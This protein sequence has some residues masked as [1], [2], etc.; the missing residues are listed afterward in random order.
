[1]MVMEPSSTFATLLRV[2]HD[3]NRTLPQQITHRIRIMDH[4]IEND[5][6]AGLRLVDASGLKIRWQMDHMK[7]TNTND[8]AN[9]PQCNLGRTA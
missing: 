4:D 8:V 3:V 9:L 5:T 1:M 6:T 7:N 2:R